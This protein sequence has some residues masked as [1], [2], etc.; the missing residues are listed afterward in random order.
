MIYKK[1]TSQIH[2]MYFTLYTYKLLKSEF[3]LYIINI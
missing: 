2:I 3:N 1:T